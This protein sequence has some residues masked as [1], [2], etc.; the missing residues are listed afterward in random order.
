MA[1]NLPRDFRVTTSTL[2]ATVLCG[3]ALFRMFNVYEA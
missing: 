3:I 2:G 1:Y